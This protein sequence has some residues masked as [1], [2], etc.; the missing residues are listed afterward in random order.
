MNKHFQNPFTVRL[1]LFCS[2]MWKAKILI[3]AKLEFWRNLFKTKYFIT[4]S[5]LALKGKLNG[6]ILLL[7]FFSCRVYV[8]YLYFKKCSAHKVFQCSLIR[9]QF[10]SF[11]TK[12]RH[13]K[14]KQTQSHQS[15]KSI[16]V[17]CLFTNN[18]FLLGSISSFDAVII[19]SVPFGRGLS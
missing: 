14:C 16:S 13:T 7:R 2:Y 4:I 11:N 19:S 6:K 10:F 18:R 5:I 12:I 15:H 1:D 17:L 8:M 3:Y 9:N